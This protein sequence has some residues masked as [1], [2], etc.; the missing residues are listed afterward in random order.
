MPLIVSSLP[1]QYETASESVTLSNDIRRNVVWAYTLTECI[2]PNSETH[3]VEQLHKRTRYQF[4]EITVCY[5]MVH[6]WQYDGKDGAQIVGAPFG[7]RY[8]DQGDLLKADEPYLQPEVAVMLGY[9]PDLNSIPPYIEHCTLDELKVLLKT[10]EEKFADDGSL[11]AWLSVPIAA[12]SEAPEDIYQT[13]RKMRGDIG[14]RPT[15]GRAKMLQYVMQMTG[16]TLGVKGWGLTP[17]EITRRRQRPN[18]QVPPQD[19]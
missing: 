16:V 17:A 14:V 6:E 1:Y 18:T 19:D 2:T 3:I 7:Y 8:Y 13:L 15:R 12:P 4:D 9:T 11:N 10:A 5:R